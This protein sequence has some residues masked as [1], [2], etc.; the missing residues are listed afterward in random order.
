MANYKNVVKLFQNYF[1]KK[2]LTRNASNKNDFLSI[3]INKLYDKIIAN[4]LIIEENQTSQRDID[5][6]NEDAQTIMENRSTTAIRK[7]KIN[8]YVRQISNK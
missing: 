5:S 7:S 8:Q 3:E 4:D 1:L 6:L 2:S